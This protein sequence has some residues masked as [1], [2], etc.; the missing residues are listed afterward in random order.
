MS[1][2]KSPI[3][4]PLVSARAFL[5][6]ARAGSFRDAALE[7]GLSPSAVSRHVKHLESWLGKPLFERGV[8][9]VQLNQAGQELVANLEGPFAQIEDALGPERRR[10]GGQV[11]LTALPYIVNHWLLEQLD[12]LPASITL[13]INTSQQVMD[14]ESE[15]FDVAI[16]N[17]HT[18]PVGLWNSKLLDLRLIPVCSADFALN[19]KK[20]ADLLDIP[21]IHLSAR[22]QGWQRW[23]KV[24]GIEFSKRP[25][26]ELDTMPAVLEAAAQGRGVALG[27]SPII[28]AGQWNQDLVVPFAS[29]PV[30]AGS[31]YLVM[32]KED[33]VRPE[34]QQFAAWIKHRLLNQRNEMLQRE[35]SVT[36]KLAPPG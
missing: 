30:E 7:L 31:Y 1:E 15:R 14:L 35:V 5:A 18:P 17:V 2:K 26:L 28:W 27:L 3:K 16:R 12:D 11:S 33:Y 19:I 25:F 20:P 36:R 9:Q 6:A 13:S 8:R 24:H 29:N 10:H 34:L 21:L 32:R 23:F 22:P 4:L